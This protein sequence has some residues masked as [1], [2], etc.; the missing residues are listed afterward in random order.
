MSAI[1]TRS[2]LP[3]Y[4][5]SQQPLNGASL[6]ANFSDSRTCHKYSIAARMYIQYNVCMFL[7]VCDSVFFIYFFNIFR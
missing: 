5:L 7:C 1:P 2:K 6:I 4:V 3:I